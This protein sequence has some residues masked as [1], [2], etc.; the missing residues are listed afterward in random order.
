MN[1]SISVVI[2]AF[3]RGAPIAR[4][5]DSALGQDVP[6]EDV[7]ILV[8]D[9]GSTDDTFAFLQS[10][11]GDNAR[12]RL[13]SIA[14]GGVAR[15]R[16]FGLEQAR[17][18]FIAFLDH[19][20]LWLPQKLRLQRE[21]LQRQSEVGVAYCLWRE[22]DEQ[23]REMEPSSVLSFEE[24]Q[25]PPVGDVFLRLMHHNFIV[26]MTL[27][28][29]RT[30]LLCE[31]GGFDPEVVPCDDWDVWLRMSRK[32]GF[33]VIN[34]VLAVYQLHENQ[35]SLAE[36]KMLSATR[37]VLIKNLK[38]NWLV[39]LRIPKVVWITYSLH[40]F[41]KTRAPF[42]QPARRSIAMRDWAGV[43][44][45]LLRGWRRFPLLFLVP[46]W[47]YIVKRLVTRDARPF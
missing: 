35:Q 3:N 44:R 5:I 43:R 47:L 11:Y 29:L 34:E 15:A 13:F 30:Q 10:N 25:H 9:D 20:D 2:P 40:Y 16:N 42:Y 28:L 8:V 19:D 32:A 37:R 46:Q 45:A 26:S 31:I 17:G 38:P 22:V 1:P 24:W 41:Y 18:E 14:N 6:P 39:A 21:L 12:V 27:P 7:E 4:T 36:E 23:G 33:G